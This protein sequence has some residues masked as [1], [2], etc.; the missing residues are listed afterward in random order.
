[1][2]GELSKVAGM[3]DGARCDMAHARSKGGSSTAGI[4]TGRQGVSAG[5]AASQG[6]G[7]R[8]Q[9]KGGKPLTPAPYSNG[10]RH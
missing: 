4:S 5:G 1:M 3:C 7:G 6:E 10:V 2:L 9:S 8:S